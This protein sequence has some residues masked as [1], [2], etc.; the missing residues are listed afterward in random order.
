MNRAEKQQFV[1]DLGLGVADAQAFALLSFSKLTVDQMTSFRLALRKKDVHVKVVK[2]TLAKRVFDT[3]AFKDLNVHLE[4]PTLLAYGK[5]DPVLTAKTI[6]EWIGKENFDIK[7][8]GG[9][10]LGQTMSEAQL[11]SLSK[12]PGKNELFVSF[13]WG[14]KSSPTK[15]LYALQDTPRKLGYAL[16]A[17]RE[18]REKEPATV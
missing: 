12:L 13:L 5:G 7:V 14:L 15:F 10:A 6:W 17:L 16:V 1:T 8:K 18:K 2:N 3:T 4:G 9:I 11:K